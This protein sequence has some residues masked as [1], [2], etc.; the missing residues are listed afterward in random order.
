M[1]GFSKNLL[2]FLILSLFLFS[3]GQQS[4]TFSGDFLLGYTGW[5][6]TP[7]YDSM[8]L[9][10][11]DGEDRLWTAFENEK[12]ILRKIDF[13][14]NTQEK[15]T[16][17]IYPDSPESIHDPY[18]SSDGSTIV[19]TLESSNGSYRDLVRIKTGTSDYSMFSLDGANNIRLPNL[20]NL[21]ITS[22]CYV[23]EELLGYLGYQ[24]D[25]NTY[26][27]TQSYYMYDFTTGNTRSI[28]L[29]SYAFDNEGNIT[30]GDVFYS[31][32]IYLGSDDSGNSY[33]MVM[34]CVRLDPEEYPSDSSDAVYTVRMFSADGEM[35]Y[36]GLDDGF[37][38]ENIGGIRW[39][40]DSSL[41]MTV[42]ENSEWKV[43]SAGE[44]G[45]T[46]EI[47][48]LGSD[49]Y[50]LSGL[51]ISP[52]GEKCVTRKLRGEYDS[53]SELIIIDLY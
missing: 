33:E 19:F 48:N 52:S 27:A 10:A 46:R 13:E 45:V 41:I 39:F 37:Q 3:C 21:Y 35:N 44:G 30:G 34:F 7:F 5:L 11:W 31:P 23:S 40:D 18:V 1:K 53:Y 8:A 51:N 22:P 42:R 4:D 43:I 6:S 47:L 15:I 29:G 17:Y 38:F 14:G 36:D 24:L 32:D 12:R 49:L 2:I 28:L 20:S 16:F 50:S 25:F 9:P 26:T